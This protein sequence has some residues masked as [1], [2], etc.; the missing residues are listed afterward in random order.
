MIGTIIDSLSLSSLV[1][2]QVMAADQSREDPDLE[3]GGGEEDN[4]PSKNSHSRFTGQQQHQRGGGGGGGGVRAVGSAKSTYES[5]KSKIKMDTSLVEKSESSQVSKFGSISYASALKNRPVVSHAV[6]QV[7]VTGQTSSDPVPLSIPPVMEDVP[8]SPTVPPEVP[9]I[10][11]SPLSWKSETVPLSPLPPMGVASEVLSSPVVCVP[12]VDVSEAIPLQTTP[13]PEPIPLPVPPQS[14]IVPVDPGVPS[15]NYPFD[16]RGGEGP[17]GAEPEGVEILA[18]VEPHSDVKSNLNITANEFVPYHRSVPENSHTSSSSP[19]TGLTP[20]TTPLGTTVLGKP[21][22]KQ[23]KST[24][25][26]SSSLAKV[27][28]TAVLSSAPPVPQQSLLN[29]P[30]PHV[31]H[32]LH[33]LQVAVL[34][35]SQQQQ[36]QQQL[37][38]RSKPTTSHVSGTTS[39]STSRLNPINHSS[40][41]AQSSSQ[42]VLQSIPHYPAPPPGGGSQ[43]I[44][45]M[46]P[47]TPHHSYPPPPIQSYQSVK[48]RVQAQPPPIDIVQTI[49][50]VHP[51]YMERA[52]GI[53]GNMAPPIHP[54]LSH[55]L[56]HQGIASVVPTTLQAPPTLYPSSHLP[57][58]LATPSHVFMS[59]ALPAG[60]GGLPVTFQQISPS[61]SRVPI[62]TPT[63]IQ[64]I[65]PKIHSTIRPPLLPTPPNFNLLVSATPTRTVQ[66]TMA[67]PTVFAPPPT[68]VW[69][70]MRLGTSL[71]G[72]G[73]GPPPQHIVSPEGH[74]MALPHQVV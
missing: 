4:R 51:S 31:L 40:S 28:P 69:T 27:P 61:L 33:Q 53:H 14:T 72:S 65:E 46:V 35:A 34:T 1:L 48:S 6:E 8:I 56:S 15:S 16:L 60:T 30:P 13:I 45:L 10:N 49:R 74:P 2:L 44:P 20:S 63:H 21:T 22:N 59:P 7:R 23:L 43:P 55:G 54:V 29:Q 12:P 3:E 11:N 17:L 36:Q 71:N 47:Y 42:P 18:T 25:M 32:V 58:Q 5:N 9:D 62:S 38:K 64:S 68:A 66:T 39:V 73:H 70:G 19:S 24:K 26:T 57:H 52:D 41:S 37:S 50:P 67:T